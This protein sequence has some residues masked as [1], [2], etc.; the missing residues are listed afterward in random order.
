MI[1]NHKLDYKKFN[2]LICQLTTNES[3][4]IDEI[5]LAHVKLSLAMAIKL[6]DSLIKVKLPIGFHLKFYERDL[7]LSV[8]EVLVKVRSINCSESFELSLIQSKLD[9]VAI[10]LFA[11]VLQSGCCTYGLILRLDKDLCSYDIENLAIALQ[12]GQCPENLHLF[13]D[14]FNEIDALGAMLLSNAIESG[15]CPKGLHLNLSNN[16]LATLNF[17]F[18]DDVFIKFFNEYK[19][20]LNFEATSC[21]LYHLA[22]VIKSNN[23][24]DCLTLDI[25]GHIDFNQQNIFIFDAIA[26]ETCE[27][28][29]TLSMRY[30]I[31]SVEI[32]IYFA[33]LFEAG[34]IPDGIIFNMEYCNF[35]HDGLVALANAITSVYFPKQIKLNLHG[36]YIMR[37]CSDISSSDEGEQIL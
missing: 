21:G 26:N 6:C 35:D 37:S 33:R 19:Y 20:Y 17:E 23:Y 25:S 34:R 9:K 11:S 2:S 1:F 32:T 16:R 24:P 27:K 18:E 30:C 13:L 10:D 22:R 15:K 31:R 5:E 7:S 14:Y 28:A 3:I 12:S 8:I 36:H 29:F 4:V